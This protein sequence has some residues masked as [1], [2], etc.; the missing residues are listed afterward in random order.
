MDIYVPFILIHYS[1]TISITSI[2]R[3]FWL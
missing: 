3:Y 2:C 1:I